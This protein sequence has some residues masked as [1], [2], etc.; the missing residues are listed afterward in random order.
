MNY[1]IKDTSQ[2]KTIHQN[3]NLPYFVAKV[4][5][6]YSQEQILDILTYQ[7]KEIIFDKMTNAV[8][9]VN[10][11][12]NKNNKIVIMGDYDCDGILAT[13]IM[14]KGFAKL[15]YE[16]GYYIPHRIKDG[17]G[18]T[19]NLVKQ[20]IAK[21]YKLIITVDNGINAQEA[22][23]YAIEH[24]VDVL[25]TDHHQVD[26]NKQ[27]NVICLH[28]QYSNLDYEVSG[29]Y[30]AYQFIKNLISYEDDYLHALAAITLISD[31]MPL[32]KG[33]RSFIRKALQNIQ[34]FNYLQINVLA[35]GFVDSS[36][37]GSVIAP[38]INSLGRLPDIYNPNTLV[39]FFCSNKKIAILN[40][41]KEIEEC[42]NVRK[43]MTNDYYQE[44]DNYTIKH[45]FLMIENDSYHE[46]LLGLLAS[47]FS[48]QEKCV[49]FIATSNK[50]EYKASIRSIP[51]IN[52]YNILS[53][54]EYLFTKLGGH[55]QA[56][57]VS[58]KKEN[59]KEIKKV[60]E[61]E[62]KD[63]EIPEKSYD[64]IKL[65]EVDLELDNIIALRYLEP[66]GNG[67]QAPLFLIDNAIV[68]T[69][70]GLKNNQHYRLNILFETKSYEVM[71]FNVNSCDIKVNDHL[72]L[73]VKLGLNNYNGQTKLNII[74]EDY[75][76]R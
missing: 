5:A 55:S 34:D 13:S 57:G 52:I 35:N 17:Y 69:M 75:L 65:D 47:R 66:F 25:V 19:I 73:I 40:Y 23:Q 41:A 43:Q 4:L 60:I 32:V 22:I 59:A 21:D 11:H 68:A 38:K 10:N 6:S 7:D 70:K 58:Y 71:L 28:P 15:N 12:V 14:V 64:V 46:G 30:V 49:S 62:L 61:N 45:N 56:M 1:Q 72:D 16:V 51:E 33:N 29:G 42:N 39:K 8:E 3:Y 67:F 9:L 53:Q 27:S 76:I 74:V 24:N 48:N 44:L 20:F 2:A 50:D 36:M 54:Y 37:I 31:V 26:L 18:L 63:L